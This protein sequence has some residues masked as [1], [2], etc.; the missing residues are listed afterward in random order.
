[1]MTAQ[2]IKAELPYFYG[3]EG[4]HR[5]SP[6]FPSFVGTDGTKFLAENAGCYWLMDAICSHQPKAMRDSML[7]DFQVWKFKKDGKG[8]GVLTCERDTDDVA[9]R[10]AIQYTDFPLDE[11]KLYVC[12]GEVQGRPVQVCM[13]TSEY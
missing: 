11:I 2:Q 3:T 4:Y 9:F 1:M 6:L 12:P 13:L 8:G 10:Q 7:R 5:L